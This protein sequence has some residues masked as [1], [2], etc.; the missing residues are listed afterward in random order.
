NTGGGLLAPRVDYLTGTN[1]MGAAIGGL[2]NDRVPDLVA[3]N[4]GD[5]SVSVLLG[6]G[7]GLF[8]NQVKYSVGGD[9]WFVVTAD[10]NNDGTK[11]LATI[12]TNSFSVSILLGAGDGS[13]PTHMEI[14]TGLGFPPDIAAGDLDG[15]GNADLAVIG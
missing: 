8:E 7:G 11:D 5:G 3:A 12:N 13:F 2:N 15:D 4:E 1:T 6:T 10:F 9:P 14:H